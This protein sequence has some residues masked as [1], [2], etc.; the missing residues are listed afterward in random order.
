MLA[1][2]IRVLGNGRA[3]LAAFEASRRDRV[4]ALIASARRNSSHKAPG[5]VGRAVRDLLLPLFL[6]LGA[7]DAERAYGYQPPALHRV[8]GAS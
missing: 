3:A 7:R 1:D 5:P 6:R 2:A 4:E 8:G